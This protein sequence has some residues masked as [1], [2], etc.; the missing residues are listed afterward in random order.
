MDEVSF[1]PSPGG[2]KW[3][4]PLLLNGPLKRNSVF[5]IFPAVLCGLNFGLEMHLSSCAAPTEAGIHFPHCR[6]AAVVSVFVLCMKSRSR[7]FLP[8]LGSRGNVTSG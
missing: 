3:G 4:Q 6:C 2:Y 8:V 5:V 1:H 7:F